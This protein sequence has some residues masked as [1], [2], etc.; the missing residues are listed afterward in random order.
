MD[1]MQ[2]VKGTVSKIYFDKGY[3]F[4]AGE[5]KRD[6]FAHYSFF[7][8]SSIA[9]KHVREGMNVDFT[10]QE[11]EDPKQGPKALDVKLAN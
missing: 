6:Y 5:D 10:P 9:F 4:I 1:N 7:L 2:R 8:R 3:C 11:N